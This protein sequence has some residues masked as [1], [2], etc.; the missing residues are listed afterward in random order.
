MLKKSFLVFMAFLVGI[1]SAILP[2]GSVANAQ[3]QNDFILTED[4][5]EAVNLSEVINLDE[6]L[7]NLNLSNDNLLDNNYRIKGENIGFINAKDNE[8]GYYYNFY[9]EN[10]EIKYYSIQKE[11]ENGHAT[12]ELYDI[13]NLFILSSEID[14]NGNLIGEEINMEPQKQDGVQIMSS[15][16]INKAAFKWACIFSSYIA[17]I[18]IAIAAGAA[19]SLVSGPFGA[20]AG[21]AGGAACRYLFQ[22]AVDKY[23]SKDKACK[24][25]S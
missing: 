14:R 18:S 2:N 9:L 6:S 17:C 3:P 16:G 22:T 24:I 21:F 1:T 20:A 4:D 8:T 10:N 13:N 15:S 19:G 7:S 11:A 5:L 23:G 25:L 12:F